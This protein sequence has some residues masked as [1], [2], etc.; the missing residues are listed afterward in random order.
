MSSPTDDR[1]STDRPTDRLSNMTTDT[2]EDIADRVRRIARRALTDA[3]VDDEV[4]DYACSLL[5]DALEEAPRAGDASDEFVEDATSALAPMLEEHG[6]GEEAVRAMC[7]SLVQRTGSGSGQSDAKDAVVGRSGNADAEDDAKG[8][9]ASTSASSS[10]LLDL[11]GIILA[12]AAKVLLRPTNLALRKG[13]RYG[14]VGHNGAGKTTLLNRI[15]AGDIAG[16]PSDV[17]CVFVRHEVL[18]NMSV[19]VVKFMEEE[20]DGFGGADAAAIETSLRSV[21]F[22]DDMMKKA[23]TELS[24]GWRM[25]LS[26]ARAMLQKAD[27]L[28][29][30]EPT[31]HLDVS[32]VEW[33]AKYLTSLREDTTV[34]CVSHDYDFLREISTHIIQFDKQQLATFDGGFDNFRAQRPN[35]VLPRMKKD[36]VDEIVSRANETGATVDAGQSTENGGRRRRAAS[37]ANRLE[38]TAGLVNAMRGNSTSTALAGGANSRMSSARAAREQLSSATIAFPEPGPL[39]GIKSKTQVVAR[40]EDLS[41]AYPNNQV[42]SGVFVRLYLGSRVAVVGA[43]GAGKTTLMKNIVGELEPTG[44]SVW[45][46]H[47]LRIAYI[48]Q[49]SMHH[50]QEHVDMSPKEYIQT[51]F[52]QGRDKEL[53]KMSTMALTDE[54]KVE[55]QSR[56][57]VSEILGRAVK[58]GELC[59]EVKKV[60]DRP[61]L[62]HWEPKRFLKASY[63]VKMC[64]NYDEMM[65]AMQSGMDIRPLTSDE[66]YAH[67]S[68]FGISQELADGKIKRMSGGQ[69]SRLVLAAA[70]WVKPHIIALDEPTNYLDNETLAALT[71]ALKKFK[72]GVLTISHNAAFVG[73]VCTDTWR[74]YQGKVTSSEDE[75]RG[76]GASRKGGARRR[77]ADKKD[78]DKEKDAEDG[79]DTNAKSSNVDKDEVE[80]SVTAVLTSRKT[81]LDLRFERVSMSVNGAELIKD[82][83]MELNVGRRYGLLGPNGCGKSMLLEA[84]ARR[85]IEVPSHVDIYHLR[86]EA[87]PSDQTALEAVVNHIREEVQRLQ[88]V[89]G[90]ILTSNGPGDER[91]QGIYERLEE[92][93]PA[94]FE[95][96]AAELLHNL[97]FDKVMMQ[98]QTKALSGGWRMRVS[99]ARALL[100]SPALLLLDEPTNH[101]DLSACVWLEEHLSQY[102][103][104]LVVVS[105]SQDFLNG[106]CSHIIRVTNKTLK[107]YT[108]DYDTFRRTLAEEEIIQTK[109]YEKEQADIKHL[110]EFIASCGTYADKMKQANS[111]QKIL[112]KMEAAGLTPS[113][114]AEQTFQLEFPECAKLAPPVLPFKDVSFRYP[115]AAPELGMLLE[116]LEFGVDCDSRIALV[117]PNGAGKSTIL[118]LM[119]GDIDAVEGEVGRHHHLSI[120]RYHQHSIDVLDPRATPVEFFAGTYYEMHKPTDEWRSY[121]GKFGITGRLQTRPIA[122]LSDGQKSRLVFAMICLGNPNMLLLDE[123]TNHLDHDAIDALADAINGYQGG[124]VLVSHDFRLID[125]VAKEIWVCENKGVSVWKDDI[126][127]YKKHLAKAAGGS[128]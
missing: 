126:R 58:G 52:Y 5:E 120:G 62:T 72:G 104:C 122:E 88:K 114:K 79:D 70:M 48:A 105:H 103:K 40:L 65:K 19:S 87:E 39:D 29:L 14:V 36:L 9:A 63:V 106:V 21:G 18:V 75:A 113:P 82:C 11:R 89:E 61:G 101:L 26:I 84:I 123:P 43:N 27:L 47:N 86:E 25:R 37:E 73:D 115:S 44:G 50:L 3:G 23:V 77:R 54:E 110:K 66:V 78:A 2:T 6:F 92:L 7:A 16:F 117:G 107:Y 80:R 116:H 91:L 90:E 1:L 68:D 100:A 15:A 41:F 60:G 74:V 30:D 28:L 125:R 32:A 17:K 35:L 97:G 67:L 8:A 81:A 22:D 98:R 102:K 118:K 71:S 56:G 33:L 13:A 85:E 4:V 76:V 38:N 24:G 96:E 108:G 128:R 64:K 12:Y 121:L 42:L 94:K 112:D 93:D 69:K 45:K 20:A 34:L 95:V 99:L 119:T 53:A 57:G 111:K 127:A 59:Y 124:L 10:L 31:N 55:Q 83:T 46:H 49:H 51:R 109:Q